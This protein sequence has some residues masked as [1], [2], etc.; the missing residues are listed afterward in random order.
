M[1]TPAERLAYCDAFVKHNGNPLEL[2]RWQEL[3]VSDASRFSIILKGRQEGFSFASAL[4]GLVKANDPDRV[5]YTRQFVS[6]NFED[7]VEKIRAARMLYDTIPVKHK[8]KLAVDNKTMLEFYDV[9]GKTT[10]RLISI[11][12]RP[13]RGRS[14]DIVLDEFAMFKK[15]A[16]QTIYTAALPVMT[17]GGCIEIGSTPL[18]LL[19]MFYEIWSDAEKYP[20]F[21]HFTVPW[22]VSSALC[23]NVEA[24]RLEDAK[25]MDTEERV[26]RFG[27]KILRKAFSNLFIE[28]FQQEYECAFID[29][30]QSYI[31]FDIIYANVP[32][33]R[34][35]D[36]WHEMGVDGKGEEID[37]EIHTAKTAEEINYD[38]GKHGRLYL[39]YDVARRRDAAV[40]FVMGLLPDGRKTS[41]AE[42]IMINKDF[43]YQLDQ[44]R[45]IMETLPVIRACIDRTGQGEMVTETLQ[46]EYG[47]DRVEGVIF[48]IISKEE[49]AVRVKMGLEKHEFLLP[50]DKRFL[51]QIHSIKRIPTSGGAFRYD[52]ERDEFGHADSFWAWALANYAITPVKESGPNF[53]KKWHE[54]REQEQRGE[55]E[56]AVSAGPEKAVR[57][58]SRDRVLR[59]ML[60]GAK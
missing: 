25:E 22:W 23:E 7:A 38:P 53:Y 21:K 37:I 51:T 27:N 35:Y 50:N 24:A 32:G 40:I 28:D 30:A 59:E 8:K 52:S 47:A 43:T 58:K 49:L 14:G 60:K 9:G 44:F 2:D 18:G 16:A 10:S 48:N 46:K 41:V 5:N 19:G 33:M 34:G 17:R 42:I 20:D 39:G 57:G 55:R 29:S 11:A 15:N 13:P 31:P 6:Y 3:Y 56:A 45:N 4:K 36:D 26:E 1:F 12:C 54:R